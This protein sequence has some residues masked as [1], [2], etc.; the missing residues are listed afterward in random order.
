MVFLGNSSVKNLAEQGKSAI[1][2]RLYHNANTLP[3]S[4]GSPCLNAKLEIIG[5]H[6]AGDA[7]YHGVVGFP[8]R[9]QA[10]PIGT[11]LAWLE[12]RLPGVF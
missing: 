11:I 12:N 7:L 2:N 4:S 10:V 9:N 6:N 3:G 8:N 1:G 5:L